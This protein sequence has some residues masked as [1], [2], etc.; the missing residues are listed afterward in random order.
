MQYGSIDV[1]L[2]YMPHYRWSKRVGQRSMNNDRWMIRRHMHGSQTN[3]QPFKYGIEDTK[4]KLSNRASSITL[5]H[6][7]DARRAMCNGCGSIGWPWLSSALCRSPAHVIAARSQCQTLHADIG[8]IVSP[9]SLRQ[10]QNRMSE[11]R[12]QHMA[13]PT[14]EAERIC[15]QPSIDSP[16]IPATRWSDNRTSVP[17]RSGCPER[18]VANCR[19]CLF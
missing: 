19:C 14:N 1:T 11:S 18:P 5:E 9:C 16:M 15:H 6:T 17:D 2:P 4:T 10:Q 7:P 8:N 13:T 12:K 3:A